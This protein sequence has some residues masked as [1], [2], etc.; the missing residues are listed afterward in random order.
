MRHDKSVNDS[1]DFFRQTL[2]HFSLKSK[3]E[4]VSFDSRHKM[5]DRA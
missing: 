2:L 3:V 1:F 4:E 5:Q